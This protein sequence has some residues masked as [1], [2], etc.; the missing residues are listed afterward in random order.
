MQSMKVNVLGSEYEMRFAT[1]KELRMDND[2]YGECYPYGKKVI[3][4]CTDL[5]S[6][7]E[8]SS[9]EK[10]EMTK[11]VITHELA[12]AFLYES[13]LVK[14]CN[15]ETLVVWLS[16]NVN[17]LVSTSLGVFDTMNMI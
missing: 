12:H 4:I 8:L 11:E 17:K 13:G 16:V 6:G 1:R 5:D 9:D 7:E 3:N 15:D 14:Y 2:T 10:L